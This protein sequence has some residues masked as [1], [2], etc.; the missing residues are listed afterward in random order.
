MT[1]HF[2]NFTENPVMAETKP[3][4]ALRSRVART[5]GALALAASLLSLPA[6]AA[7][8]MAPGV[9]VD[10]ARSVAYLTNP[11][12]AIEALDLATGSVL[13]TSSTPGRP[14]LVANQQLV[15][16]IP[17]KGGALALA[18]LDPR[19]A[20]VVSPIAEV[21][22]PT[23]A[24]AGLRD[25]FEGAFRISGEALSNEEALVRWSYQALNIK[26]AQFDAVTTGG[27]NT[28]GVAPGVLAGAVRLNLGSGLATSLSA[29]EADRLVAP[30][31]TSL[32]AEAQ[33]LASGPRAFTSADGRHSLVS[34]RNPSNN[35]AARYRWTVTDPSNG[36]VLGGIESAVST[37]PFVVHGSTLLY[38]RQ[39]AMVQRGAAVT[40][41]ELSLT[42][43]DLASGVE[44][45]HRQ[46]A[47]TRL[48]G[49]FPP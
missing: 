43:V 19:R 49:P 16:Q 34:Q 26:G 11:A 23:G 38:L 10:A 4:P 44:L 1:T 33:A 17:G 42:A 40:Q 32:G 45:W 35:P 5:A 13:W 24:I 7:P 15:A 29:T 31:R 41:V 9:V 21:K 37:A 39:P 46:V 27:P 14:I 47:D 25:T 2:E 30:R 3:Q 48:R 36:A 6:A 8:A 22:L 18:V 28:A 12:G 20:G